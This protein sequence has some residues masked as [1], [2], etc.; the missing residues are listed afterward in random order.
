MNTS[1]KRYVLLR[2][3]RDQML[4]RIFLPEFGGQ[5]YHLGD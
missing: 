1:E 3:V 2:G 4:S 5:G